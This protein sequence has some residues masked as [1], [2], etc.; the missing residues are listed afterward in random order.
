MNADGT[1]VTCLTNTPAKSFSPAW[2]PDGKRIAFVSN[3]EGNREIYAMNADGSNVA[4]LTNDLGEDSSPAWSPDGK[5]IA[6]VSN[7]G[8]KRQIYVTLAPH[9]SAGVGADGSPVTRLG[10]G[11]FDDDMPTWAPK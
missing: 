4:R 2:S 8:G 11:A 3:R 5:Q 9:A 7:R 1:N 6:F 10:V